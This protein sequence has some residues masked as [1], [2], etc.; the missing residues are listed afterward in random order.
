MGKASRYF[1]AVGSFGH[2]WYP[3]DIV[4]SPLMATGNYWFVNS[5][6]EPTGSGKSWDSAFSDFTDA[7]S[8]VGSGDVIF[9]APGTYTGNYSTPDETE[10]RNV[11]V[12][13][14]APGQPGIR[15]GVNL[16]PTSGASP[17]I[18]NNASGWRYSNLCFRPGATSS[19]ITLVADQNTTAYIAGTA[20]SISQGVTVDNCTF[21]GGGTGKYGIIAAGLADNNGINFANIINNHFVY[22]NATGASAIF[23]AASGNPNIGWNISGNMFESN[24]KGIS[25]YANM[26]WVGS[27]IMD[28]TFG[29]GGV[30]AS[31]EVLCDV[32][33]TAT[34]E[35]TGG[36]HFYGNG[37]GITKAQAA[38]GTY[39]LL[40]GYDNAGGNFCS[41]GI[42]TGIY[43]AT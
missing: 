40:N 35:V 37:L 22:L 18:T 33:S 12:I 41:D 34:P 43:K 19:G 24:R 7:L 20:G 30:Y 42:D 15:G 29:V 21:W 25:T 11:S 36:N 26:G 14:V 17:I 1:P 28:N 6:L 38:A 9:M 31:T 39:V 32:S 27:R 8:S 5:N 23:A 2:K 13:G 10:A 16:L 3:E 4:G